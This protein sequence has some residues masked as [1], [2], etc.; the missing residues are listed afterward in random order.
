MVRLSVV[1]NILQEKYVE[2]GQK[3][4]IFIQSCYK[5][6]ILLKESTV[7]VLK[8]LKLFSSPG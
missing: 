3:R 6:K 7:I 8:L 2:I 5:L 1:F 4:H